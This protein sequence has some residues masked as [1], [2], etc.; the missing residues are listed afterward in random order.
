MVLGKKEGG[1]FRSSSPSSNDRSKLGLAIL[2]GIMVGALWAY[3]HPHAFMSASE[4]SGRKIRKRDTPIA[5]QGGDPLVSEL[6]K[7]IRMLELQVTTLRGENSEIKSAL[8]LSNQEKKSAQQQ[9][10]ASR[11]R[12]KA[13]KFGT[14]AGTTTHPEII[15]DKS[16]NPELAQL[17]EKIAINRELIVGV[18]N[19]NV[20]PM[21]Q[22]WFESIKQSGI[23]NYLVVALD[24]ETAKFCKD[25]DVP[26][27][28]KDATIPKSLAGTGDNHAISGTKFHILREFL[29]LGYSVLL[30]DVD[31]VYLQNPF[32]FLQRDCD[33]E[34]MTDGH[35]NATA[36]GYNDV[37]DDPKMGWSRY[38]HTMR[39]WVFNSGLFYL[40]PTVPS[41]ELLDRVATR[42]AREKAW[43]QAV[44]NEELFF[45]SRPGYN[46]LHASKRVMDRFLFMNSKLLFTDIRGDPSQYANFRPVTIHVNYHPDKYNRMLAIVD[47]YVKGK[48]DALAKFP[49]GSE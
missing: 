38:A 36:Y 12:V 20:A 34:A 39:I 15:P 4:V 19:K 25:H 24:D 31:I 3:L 41:I 32:K 26:A 43:D 11:S 27:Y 37:F 45:P 42:L 7:K 48:K 22:V 9:L 17:L 28:R 44:I 16:V 47:Y 40:R 33:V 8:D 14:V 13:G 49:V 35:T 46:G 1:L 30:S 29:V 23:T 5:P 10:M 18:S 21:L 6:E 2:A